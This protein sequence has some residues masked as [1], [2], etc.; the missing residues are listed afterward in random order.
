MPEVK[1]D[2]D[3]ALEVIA[4]RAENFRWIIKIGDKEVSFKRDEIV[5]NIKAGSETGARFI[6]LVKERSMDPEDNSPNILGKRYVCL[7]CET[8]A[9]TTKAGPGRI[10]CCD[11]N[12]EPVKPRPVPGAD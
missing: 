9:L 11:Q 4:S 1:S 5:E 10:Q 3:T 6:A 2:K 7:V 12:M 8:Q